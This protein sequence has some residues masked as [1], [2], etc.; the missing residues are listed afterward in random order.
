VGQ[1]LEDLVRDME[2]LEDG[3]ASFFLFFIFIFGFWFF[4][5]WTVV[6]HDW[7]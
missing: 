1:V 4:S 7:I 6:G 5:G 3:L 2:F